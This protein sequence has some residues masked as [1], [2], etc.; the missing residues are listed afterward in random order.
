MPKQVLYSATVPLGGNALD[1]LGGN[2]PETT[3]KGPVPYFISYVYSKSE[4]PYRWSA[5]GA[6]LHVIGWICALTFD[7]MALTKID[8]DNDKEL[9]DYWVYGMVIL[10]VGLG[11]VVLSTIVHM[12][13]KYGIQPGGMP[14]ALIAVITAGV[15]LSQLFA[16]LSLLKHT[17]LTKVGD[18]KD[19]RHF[20]IWGLVSKMYV[21]AVLRNNIITAEKK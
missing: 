4:S 19:L 10:A 15:T 21:S 3:T 14:P 11:F 1:K 17:Q 6:I 7:I 20:L 12:A 16:F 9:M 13:S 2:N 8:G 5:F 18:Q